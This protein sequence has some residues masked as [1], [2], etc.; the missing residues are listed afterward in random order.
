MKEV[1]EERRSQAQKFD[2]ALIAVGFRLP[3]SRKKNLLIC[4]AAG[5]NCGFAL[6]DIR[7]GGAAKN[8]TN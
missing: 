7:C 6:I 8:S 1:C 4:L 2:S 5:G 3:S